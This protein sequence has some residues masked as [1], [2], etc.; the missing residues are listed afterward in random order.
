MPSY[1]VTAPDGK[2]YEITAPDGATQEQ[3]LAYAKEMYGSAAQKPEEGIV[4]SFKKGAEQ[5]ISTG[6][7]AVESLYK[8]PE[9]AALA[10]QKR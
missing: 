6:R 7:T 5:L 10:G 9:E 4:G 8:T 3:V 1:D 2:V